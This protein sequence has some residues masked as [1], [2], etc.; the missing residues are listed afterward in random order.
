MTTLA[1]LVIDFFVSFGMVLGGSLLG[2]LGALLVHSQP[3]ATMLRL[4]DQL[5]IWAMVSALGGTMDTLRA[6]ETGLLKHD[7]Y[8]V[9]KQMT[10]LIIA[11]L[12]CQ[13]GA[14]I[15]QWLAEGEVT[16]P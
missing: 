8:I 9:G 1:N 2:G 4:S 12:G 6:L 13:V 10:Y 16:R 7:L 5:K 15:I 14:L 11:F 3:L